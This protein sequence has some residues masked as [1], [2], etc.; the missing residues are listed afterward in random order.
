MITNFL[1]KVE[2]NA[3]NSD[4]EVSYFVVSIENTPG[5]N[6]LYIAKTIKDRLM[7]EFG[8]GFVSSEIA[9]WHDDL[10]DQL[11]LATVR[12]ATHPGSGSRLATQ[13]Y[14]ALKAVT[15]LTAAKQ[16]IEEFELKV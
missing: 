9:T 10:E 7:V 2:R 14:Q 4:E 16:I 15:S 5:T 11:Q 1:Q 13:Y 3:V 12:S 8:E 6:P